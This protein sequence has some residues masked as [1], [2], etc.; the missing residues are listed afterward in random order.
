MANNIKQYQGG[1]FRTGVKMANNIK[2]AIYN[3]KD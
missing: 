3:H 2:V 1:N